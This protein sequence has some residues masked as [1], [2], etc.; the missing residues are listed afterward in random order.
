MA[1]AAPELYLGR[2]PAELTVEEL[3]LLEND[4]VDIDDNSALGLERSM[5][6]LETMKL[7]SSWDTAPYAP[8]SDPL[9][10]E[11][12][13]EMNNFDETDNVERIAELRQQIVARYPDLDI[14]YINLDPTEAAH[15]HKAF[16]SG[17]LMSRAG[18]LGLAA[19]VVIGG[20]FVPWLAAAKSQKQAGKWFK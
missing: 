9:V 13:H 5:L 4:E 1:H 11:F 15:G 18:A 7:P 3:E 16:H 14:N 10:Q 20:I 2:S 6:I 17:P 12:V 19:F 8:L